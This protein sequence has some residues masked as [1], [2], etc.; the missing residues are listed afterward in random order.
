MYPYGGTWNFDAFGPAD[1]SQQEICNAGP[2]RIGTALTGYQEAL[3]YAPPP[4]ERGQAQGL[5]LPPADRVMCD[6]AAWQRLFD[7]TGNNRR[8]H[9]GQRPCTVNEYYALEDKFY[10]LRDL[11]EEQSKVHSYTKEVATQATD[12]ALYHAKELEKAEQLIGAL[13]TERRDHWKTQLFYCLAEGSVTSKEVLDHAMGVCENMTTVNDLKMSLAKAERELAEFRAREQRPVLDRVRE[14][15]PQMTREEYNTFS[16]DFLAWHGPQDNVEWYI[17][18]IFP[19]NV[20]ASDLDS[21]PDSDEMMNDGSATD[22]KENNDD[23]DEN[24]EDLEEDDDTNTK[25]DN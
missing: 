16:R 17:A 4:Y 18:Q 23:D 14:L 6:V 13:Q 8:L 1:C 19:G 12:L 15:A 7:R 22:D 24:N 9:R 2:I 10:A 21:E 25:K 5:A 11:Y 3:S 20:K